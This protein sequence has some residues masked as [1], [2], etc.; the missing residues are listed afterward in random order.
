MAAHFE[1][2]FRTV[3]GMRG[4]IVESLYGLYQRDGTVHLRLETHRIRPGGPFPLFLEAVRIE[5]YNRQILDDMCFQVPVM[6]S[7]AP[8]ER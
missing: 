2:P 8:E 5:K 6:D 1:I 3:E 4:E 7:G